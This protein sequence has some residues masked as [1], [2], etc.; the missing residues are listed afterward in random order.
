MSSD[1]STGSTTPAVCVLACSGCS[2]AGELADHTARRLQQ[3][4]AARMSCLA[5]VGGRIPSIMATV[6]KA[7]G[8][9]MIDGCPLECG[10]NVLRNAGFTSFKQLKLHEL[11]VRKHDSGAVDETSVARLANEALR[12]LKEAS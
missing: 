7:S 10:A 2:A 5:G 8:I 6:Q 12:W 1:S 11:N 3:M 9:L 4:G